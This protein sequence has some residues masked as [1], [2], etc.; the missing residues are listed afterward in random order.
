MTQL[1]NGPAAAA[2]VATTLF[3]IA[4]ALGYN[5]AI[6]ARI[7]AG[8]TDAVTLPGSSAA[9]P[10]AFSF[11]AVGLGTMFRVGVVVTVLTSAV[12]VVLSTILVP[13]FTLL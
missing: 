13:A 6:L 5:S 4:D 1:A 2:M 7:I 9:T 3:P 10:A 12:V 8:T 11:G